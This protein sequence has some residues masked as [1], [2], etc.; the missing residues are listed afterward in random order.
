MAQLPYFLSYWWVFLWLDNYKD[1]VI[2]YFIP[3]S[4]NWLDCDILFYNSGGGKIY[5]NKKCYNK[6]II[7]SPGMDV[8]KLQPMEKQGKIHEGV[9]L[10][11]PQLSTNLDHPGPASGQPWLTREHWGWRHSWCRSNQLVGHHSWKVFGRAWKLL[12]WIDLP[13]LIC[14]IQNPSSF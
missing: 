3:L 9:D 10:P 7:C 12:Q 5:I 4:A 11:N 14:Q 1:N 6:N 8:A 2:H 13:C